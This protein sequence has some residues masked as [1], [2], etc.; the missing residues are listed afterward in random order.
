M[1]FFKQ[2]PF[3]TITF[4]LLTLI[5]STCIQKVYLE[6]LD[7]HF[8]PN[9]EDFKPGIWEELLMRFQTQEE[10]KEAFPP[11]EDLLVTGV[12]YAGMKAFYSRLKN[13]DEKRNSVVRILHFGDSII[14]AD[15][16]T[17]RMKALFQRDFGDG[18]RGVVPLF[19]KL[20]RTVLDHKNPTPEFSF[21][22]E[23][24]KPWGSLNPELGFLGESFSPVY[25]QSVSYHI[26]PEKFEPWTR[27]QVISHLKTSA[28]LLDSSVNYQIQSGGQL[29][30]EKSILSKGKC[31]SV[32]IDFSPTKEIKF[33]VPSG[34][35]LPFI[36]AL[37]LETNYGISYSPIS[38]M[39]L[40]ISDLLTVPEHS[41]ACGI[42]EFDPSL[43]VLQFGVNESQN[44]WLSA[45]RNPAFYES[46][47][48]NVV[49]RFKKFAPNASILLISPVERIRRNNQGNFI[50]MPE[51]MKI[52]EITIQ[53]AVEEG[54]AYFDSLKALGGE[55]KSGELYRAGI[56]QEDRTHLTRA[57]GD[58]LGELIY[59]EIYNQYNLFVGKERKIEE[60]KKIESK[61]ENDKAVHFTSK[62]YIYFL[63]FVLVTGLVLQRFP[64]IKIFF[65][66][67]FSYYFYISWNFYPVFLLIFS[68]IVDYYCAHWIYK[69]QIAGR[70]GLR[71]LILSLMSNLGLL[72]FFKYFNFSL[73]ILGSLLDH[74]FPNYQILLPV[75]ISFYT[76]QTLS[77]TIDVY[78]K[79]ILPEQKYFKFS[80]YVAFFPQL[81]AGPIVRASEFLP[82]MNTNARHFIVDNAKFSRAIFLICNGI[83]LKL[84][85]DWLGVNLIDRVYTTPEMYTSMETL[86]AVYAYSIQIYGDFAG[87]S[88]IAI[89]SALLLGFHLT[90]NFQ[91]PYQAMSITDFWR[92]WHISLSHWFRDYLYIPLGG[93]KK[94]VYFNLWVTMFLC[95][96]WHGAG[97]NF[98][99]WGSYHGVLLTIERIFSK[100]KIN[101]FP[102]KKRELILLLK[103]IS[104]G[105]LLGLNFF[106]QIFGRFLKQGF[107]RVILWI[108]TFHL[109]V[110][111]WVLF[112]VSSFAQ[113]MQIWENILKKDWTYPNLD[114]QILSLIVCFFV[115]H[116]SP[117]IW[118]EKISLYWGNLSGSVQGFTLGVFTLMCFK[119][120]TSES[121][122]F[123]YFQ[124]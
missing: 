67:L 119:L 91:R 69:D 85:A 117:S 80:L 94:R 53:T 48:R 98:I 26:S 79:N 84:I 92:R 52:R 32:R 35:S 108:L 27:A 72:F 13:L 63:F 29:V 56:I 61:I 8:F 65:L 114:Y 71:F 121:K 17:L 112:R 3:F 50:T 123:I 87:Y 24:A 68:T 107:L 20:E 33:S 115:I 16:L 49:R 82:N 74:E 36:D 39:G 23:R 89:G 96:L 113:A 75:G 22:R 14:W 25:F 55:G 109:I 12:D 103:S 106:F 99:I 18:G 78:R 122:A 1:S 105:S 2:K 59:K 6:P 58:Y 46:A 88:N 77:Y 70:R 41:F 102:A 42:Q 21:Q 104:N 97:L 4:W 83:L 101:K 11:H 66:L 40:E 60:K 15:I 54:V 73:A 38:I 57:G 110:F 5:S 118:K 95:G 86:F 124:F 9:P 100:K 47:F 62:S 81:V 93:N 116:L 120:A 45:S 76:F 64:S 51:M 43:I 10:H 37:V 19:H 31:S 90:K 28:P 7:L 111:G 34:S 30:Q 44:L